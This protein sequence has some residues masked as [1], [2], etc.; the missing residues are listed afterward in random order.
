MLIHKDVN[1]QLSDIQQVLLGESIELSKESSQ[2]ILKSFDF[3]QRFASNKTIYGINTGLGPMA[4]YKVDDGKQIEL[5]YNLIRSHCAGL[6]Q[7]IENIYAR[8]V[9]ICRLISLAKGTSGVHPSLPEL[10]VELINR[11]ICPLIPEHGSVGASGDLVQLSHLAVVLIGEGEVMYKG[12]RRKTSEVFEE[13]G[14]KPIKIVLREGLALINGT[15]VMTAIGLI[16][17]IKAKTLLSW[18]VYAT[19]LLSEVVESF[20]DYFSEELNRAKNHKGQQLIAKELRE[21]LADSNLIRSR[22]T[23]FFNGCNDRIHKRKVQEYYS[24]RCLPQIL[25]PVLDTID[26]A[27]N[28]VVGELNSVS[29]NPV[30]DSEL[31]NVF[32]GGN[33]HGDYVSLEMDK[34]KLVITRLAMLAERQINFLFN[35]KLNDKLPPFVN[36]G[37][38]GLNLGMQGTQFT[39]TST[40]AECQTLSTSMY[41]HSIPTNNDNQ[42]I[43]SMGT[44][45]ALLAARVIE[46]A[47]QVISVEILGLL[48]AV[49]YLRIEE[50]LSSRTMKVYTDLRKLAPVFVSDSTKH[51]E[52]RTIAEYLKNNKPN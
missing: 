28:I 20:G 38:L 7:N 34:L 37:V 16:N 17:I 22:E 8:T 51:V 36:L 41:I 24:I 10:L 47:F 45:S 13:N 23:E 50:K 6:G 15:S 49:D 32:H 29:D 1:I 43:V 35:K 19:A 4:Q 12:I 5:Q 42:D 52:L 30:V 18:S 11:D 44:N 33:F 14:L 40:T 3:L 31:E 46:N 2:A 26:Y 9:M 27:E 48:Q 39:A 25:G 21:I